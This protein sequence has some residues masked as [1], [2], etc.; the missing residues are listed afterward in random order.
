MGTVIVGSPNLPYWDSTDT[1]GPCPGADYADV[2][3]LD[4]YNWPTA[5]D[6][7]PRRRRVGPAV[8][9]PTGHPP[10]AYLAAQPDVM[11]FVWFHLKK[12]ANWR[13]NRSVSS[14]SALNVALL[15]RRS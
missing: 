4:G 12:E 8:P 3:A 14:A 9:R 5:W 1:A 2:V 6:G 11:G 10:G 15:A 13:S 7:L